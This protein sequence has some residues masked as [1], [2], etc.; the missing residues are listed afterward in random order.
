MTRAKVERLATDGFCVVRGVLDTGMLSRL[1]TWSDAQL[2]QESPEHFE[3]FRHHGSMIALDFR[4]PVAHDLITWPA[5]VAALRVLGFVDPK[6]LS[7]YLISKPPSS[8]ALWWHQDWWAWDEPESFGDAPPQLFAMYYTRD[9]NEVDGCLR[10]IPG[11]HRRPHRLHGELPPAHGVELTDSEEAERA[12]GRQLDEA[13]VAVRAGDVV[14]GDVR[15]LHATHPNHS[16]Q[17]RTCLT[18][19]YLPT[20]KHL[21]ARLKAYLAQHPSQPGPQAW[22]NGDVSERLAPLLGRYTGDEEPAAYNRTPPVSWWGL[23]SVA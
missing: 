8:P 14:L 11:S 22:Q 5:T 23:A 1:R 18:V 20:Y 17:R 2:D 10:V 7:G 6:W 4:D 15:L 21:S 19:W 12:L 13:S 3:Q 16:Q 9:V